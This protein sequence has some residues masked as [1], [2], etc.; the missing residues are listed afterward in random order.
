LKT[1]SKKPVKSFFSFFAFFYR[2][3]QLLLN[4]TPLIHIKPYAPGF[5]AKIENVR[6]GWLEENQVKAQTMTSDRRFI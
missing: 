6:S 3:E 1:L 5:D 2:G 4:N